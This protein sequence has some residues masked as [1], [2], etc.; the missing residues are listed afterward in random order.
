MSQWKPM[1]LRKTAVFLGT[2]LL[3]CGLSSGC[4]SPANSVSGEGDSSAGTVSTLPP[5]QEFEE[6]D[7]E[8]GQRTLECAVYSLKTE[9]WV[10]FEPDTGAERVRLRYKLSS[11]WTV[12]GPEFSEGQTKKGALVGAVP[13]EGS[14]ELPSV[15]GS[16]A[17]EKGCVTE[18][19]LNSHTVLV[20]TTERS[21]S[22]SYLYMVDSGKGYAVCFRFYAEEGANLTVVQTDA[23]TVVK[24]LEFLS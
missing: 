6:I 22:V 16:A 24:S 21:G 2:V 23:D 18:K 19:L 1:G 14:A 13:Y 17:D 12:E 8:N 7:N 4:Q 20:R 15:G 3:F 5:V 9:D 10:S 11:D